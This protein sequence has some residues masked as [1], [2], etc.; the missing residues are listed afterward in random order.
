MAWELATYGPVVAV[1]TAGPLAGLA[2]RRPRAPLRRHLEGAG[3]RAHARRPRHRPRRRRD[4]GAA[5]GGGPGRGRRPPGQDG[6]HPPAAAGRRP[7]SPVDVHGRGAGSRP[8]PWSTSCP[9]TSVSCTPCRS[10][11]VEAWPSRPRIDRDEASYRTAVDRAMALVPAPPPAA[12]SPPPAARPARR[13]PPATP[14]GAR[15]PAAT[16]AA[17]PP[18]TPAGSSPSATPAAAPP[19]AP[20]AGAPLPAGRG[21]AVPVA[22]VTASHDA[23]ESSLRPAASL[24]SH[25]PAHRRPQRRRPSPTAVALRRPAAPPG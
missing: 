20:P 24:P 22:R 23:D 14:A 2:R 6:L 18:A 4:A 11:P 8:A 10:A 7:C 13:S 1:G 15:P 25:W 9:R 3:G 19:P 12:T 16:E 17:P 5:L 21:H